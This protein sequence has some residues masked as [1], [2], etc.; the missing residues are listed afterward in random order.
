MKKFMSALVLVA[1]ASSLA[2]CAKVEEK[3][4]EMKT[5]AP[6]VVEETAKTTSTTTT[7]TAPDAMT[8]TTATTTTTSST[9]TTTSGPATK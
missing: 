2:A 5:E 9:V 8:A 6:K 1:V 3:K 4:P 7:T